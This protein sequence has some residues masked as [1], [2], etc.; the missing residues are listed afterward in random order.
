MVTYL[1]HRPLK[2]ESVTASFTFPTLIMSFVPINYLHDHLGATNC[3]LSPEEEAGCRGGS[4]WKSPSYLG[5]GTC[6]ACC[7]SISPCGSVQVRC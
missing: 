4:C 5:G 6:P 1:H 3:P 7:F 2:V